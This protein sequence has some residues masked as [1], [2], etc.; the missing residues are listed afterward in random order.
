M[1]IRDRAYDVNFEQNYDYLSVDTGSGTF[2]L[3]G[4]GTGVAYGSGMFKLRYTTDGSVQSPGVNWMTIQCG[5]VSSD[6]GQLVCHGPRCG[7]T[8]D[9]LQNSWNQTVSWDPCAGGSFTYYIDY[10]TEYCYDTITVGVNSYCGK[11]SASAFVAGPTTV[12]VQTDYSVQSAG[13][14]SLKAVCSGW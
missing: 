3:T 10:D 6:P 5:W 8:R 13:I 1:C 4:A 11:G 9:P 14:R 12:S 7:T 2:S